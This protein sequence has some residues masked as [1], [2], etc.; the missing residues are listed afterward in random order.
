MPTSSIVFESLLSVG[1]RNPN[2]YECK[3][4]SKSAH[5]CAIVF[6]VLNIIYD[7]K[8]EN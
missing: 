8:E 3:N 6:K 5:I 2:E 7:L 1:S 4:K